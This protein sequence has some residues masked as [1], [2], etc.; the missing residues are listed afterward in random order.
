M[1]CIRFF[2]LELGFFIRGWVIVIICWKINYLFSN[3]F[4]MM[5]W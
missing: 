5:K 3:I 4:G 2:I 1:S